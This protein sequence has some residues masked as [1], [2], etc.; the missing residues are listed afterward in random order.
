MGGNRKFRK[1]KDAEGNEV[2]SETSSSEDE[3]EFDELNTSQNARPKSGKISV[4]TQ[5]QRT[6]RSKGIDLGSI[7]E[8][9]LKETSKRGKSRISDL[10]VLDNSK[11]NQTTTANDKE[12]KIRH[13]PKDS[14][15]SLAVDPNKDQSYLVTLGK[16][17]EQSNKPKDNMTSLNEDMVGLTI[18]IM[19]SDDSETELEVE[20]SRRKRSRSRSRSK[21]RDRSEEKRKQRRSRSRERSRSRSR[22]TV[23]RYR[24]DPVVQKLV[25]DM[26]A[27]QVAEALKNSG[28]SV[29]PKTLTNQQR[30]K[31]PSDSELYTPAIKR[32][33]C[34]QLGNP[35]A[36][37]ISEQTEGN[38]LM[39]EF[40][41]NVDNPMFTSQRINEELSKIRLGVNTAQSQ[42]PRP[43]TSEAQR[44]V[45]Q[46][47][48]A[49]S[50][51]PRMSV[52]PNKDRIKNTVDQA[53]LDA[54]RF[55]ATLQQPVPGIKFNN[56]PNNARCDLDQ[57][58]QL[59]YLDS[60]DDEFFHT[61]CHIDP[62]MRAK[63]EKGDFVELEKLLQRKLMLD[64]EQDGRMHLVNRDGVSYFVKAIDRDTKIHN[65]SKWE[66]AFRTYITIYCGANP[67]R[68]AEI[69]QYVNVI[70]RASKIFN[71]ENVARYDYVFRQLMAVKPHRS[72]AKIYT[73]M[74]NINLNEPI[75]RF[76]EQNGK[77][78]GGMGTT[79]TKKDGI[80]W[81]FNKNTCKFGKS[82][83]FE[84]RCSYCNILGHSAAN[85]HRKQN[86]GRKSEGK[87]EQARNDHGKGGNNK[88]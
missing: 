41:H 8:I 50:V 54:E 67:H 42:D 78:G 9:K 11:S 33:K 34:L 57:I 88:Q 60:E 61:T 32:A 5:T 52:E 44:G 19:F 75:K 20:H 28:I 38:D 31:S 49:A 70:H 68:S 7:D 30:V 56:I 65:Y 25:K 84:H 76:Q 62:Q 36:S 51:P 29:T 46:A 17:F 58:K 13:S 83:K 87:S 63:I 2:D 37:V 43:T 69:L 74:W 86:N 66:Q 10:K 21:N 14:N 80:C 81:R 72:W 26:V 12:S 64:P 48:A 73:Q 40:L 77:S 1:E 79:S 71:W 4:K 24:E 6:T 85:C 18:P 3:M 39:E 45:G 55:K 82:C 35:T 23:E 27:E 22:S 47:A 53:I 16:K 59:R 15:E